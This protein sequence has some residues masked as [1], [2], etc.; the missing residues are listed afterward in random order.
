MNF[1]KRISLGLLVAAL[2]LFMATAAFATPDPGASESN[3]VVQNQGDTT[4]NVVVNYYGRNGA[5]QLS[6]QAAIAPGAVKEFKTADTTLAAGFS[7]SAVVSSDQPLA[8]IVSLRNSG[9][10]AAVGGLTQGAYNATISPAQVIQ[11]PSVWG[12]DSIGSYVTIQN[13]E[14]A[15]TVLTVDFFNRAGTDLGSRT[16][17]L[18]GYGSVTINMGNTANLPPN[19]PANFQD[20]SITVT[21]SATNI[22]GASTAHWDNRSDAYQALTTADAGTVLYA[23]SHFRFKANASDAE[24]TLFSALNIQNTTNAN[25]P[26]TIDYFTRGDTSGTP[27]LTLNCTV[28]ANSAVGI[29]VSNGGSGCG[30]TGNS[31]NAL[32]TSWDGSVRVTSTQ[33]RAL[34]G[35]GIT[36]WGVS[37]YNGIY[38]LVTPAQASDTIYIPA[39]YRRAPGGNWAQWSAINLQNIGTTTVTRANLTIRYIDTNGNTLLTL[40]GNALPSNLAPGAAFGLNTRNGGDLAPSAFNGLG[41]DFIGGI[42]VEGPAGSDL[43]AVNNIVYSNRASTYNGVP[44]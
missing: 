5:L 37:G 16:I 25:A 6:E 40:T 39:Q 36:T 27:A 28:P 17:N 42:I 26:I 35:T 41:N 32:G 18:N 7:G 1:A 12:F 20:G 31:F 3:A 44:K 13:T 19:W 30:F 33:N 11:F 24:Y 9:V 29:N 22:A 38:A 23:P 2:S 43:V 4:A 15:A 21:S 10:T 34:V 8:A 14:A